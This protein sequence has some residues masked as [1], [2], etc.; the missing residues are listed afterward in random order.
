MAWHDAR[1]RRLMMRLKGSHASLQS[2]RLAR[3][4][5]EELEGEI[6]RTSLVLGFDPEVALANPQAA[7]DWAR[8]R[9]ATRS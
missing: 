9:L 3:M 2:A 7:L 5:D 8:D 1:L 6:V 4:T